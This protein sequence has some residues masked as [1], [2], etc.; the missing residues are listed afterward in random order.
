[1][2]THTQLYNRMQKSEPVKTSTHSVIDM[3]SCTSA[4]HPLPE[5]TQSRGRDQTPNA[6]LVP[7]LTGGKTAVMSYRRRTHVAR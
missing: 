1:M 4:K 3:S 6:G 5:S 2:H 7:G